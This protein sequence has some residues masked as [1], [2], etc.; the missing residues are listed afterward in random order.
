MD[1]KA[2]VPPQKTVP[3]KK[4]Q[5]IRYRRAIGRSI[6]RSDKLVQSERLDGRLVDRSGYDQAIVSL[7]I[8]NR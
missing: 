8:S 7:V 5:A 1:E 4:A 6:A 2:T 3:A